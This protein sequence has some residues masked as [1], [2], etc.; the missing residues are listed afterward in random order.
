[1]TANVCILDI[2]NIL[3][4]VI[5]VGNKVIVNVGDTFNNLTVLSEVQ[6]S[7]R[8]Y[9]R[10]LCSCGNECTIALGHLRNGH[11]KSCGKCKGTIIE[12]RKT[13]LYL[14]YRAMIDR[15]HSKTHK[16]YP[17]Y[18]NRG[19]TVCD[20]WLEDYINFKE[21][22]LVSGYAE[23]LTIDRIDNESGYS[24][25]NCRWVSWNIQQRNRRRSKQ[26]SSKYIGV[27]KTK[28]NTWRAA[29]TYFG[30]VIP[31][32]SYKTEEE[33]G[34]ARDEYILKNNLEGYI[35]NNVIPKGTCK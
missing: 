8:R 34:I 22:A 20:E 1:M 32:G 5:A 11:S 23:G 31:L 16:A 6:D 3:L 12:G 27:S 17:N 19:I 33:A 4:G 30:E 7:Q 24:P 14:V 21:W 15:C 2:Y 13:K 28:W 10:C 25:E 9:I 18:G 29:V 26:G 35:M